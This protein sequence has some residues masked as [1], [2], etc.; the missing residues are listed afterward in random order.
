MRVSFFLIIFFTS[1]FFGFSKH[2]LTDIEPKIY[3]NNEYFLPDLDIM[4]DFNLEIV[5]NNCREELFQEVI[6][7][8]QFCGEFID[9][10]TDKKSINQETYLLE[11]DMNFVVENEELLNFY[12]K[13]NINLCRETDDVSFYQIIKS[14]YRTPYRWGG[15]SR[16]G[17]DC[18]GFVAVVHNS[19]QNFDLPGGAGSQFAVCDRVAKNQLQTGD[20]VFFTIG[21]YSISHVGVY[22]KD[23]KFAHASSGGY[24]V[25]ISD[26]N[27]SYYKRW[28][29]S[30]GRVNPDKVQKLSQKPVAYIKR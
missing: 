21:T 6:Y 13:Y 30:G 11:D 25:I 14:W 22:L 23:G 20:L 29:F 16:K 3:I 18:Q 9:E 17:V 24:G 19:Y 27:E 1:F 12:G 8:D 5:N 28:Y 15:R 7:T 4:V 26:L 2:T 10:C